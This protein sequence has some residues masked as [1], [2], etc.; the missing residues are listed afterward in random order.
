MSDADLRCCQCSRLR[1]GSQVGTGSHN[2]WDSAGWDNTC[3]AELAPGN[4]RWVDS[5]LDTCG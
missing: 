5:N 1:L 4:T 3:P 2:C